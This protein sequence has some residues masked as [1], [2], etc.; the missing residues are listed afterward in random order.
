MYIEYDC[1]ISV[2]HSRL[3]DTL[4]NR[5]VPTAVIEEVDTLI[6]EFSL[7]DGSDDE[8]NDKVDIKFQS[9]S[10]RSCDKASDDETQEDCDDFY[11]KPSDDEKDEVRLND[12]GGSGDGYSD[13]NVEIKDDSS[14]ADSNSD[15]SDIDITDENESD[16]V[17]SADVA[18]ISNGKYKLLLNEKLIMYSTLYLNYTIMDATQALVCKTIGTTFQTVLNYQKPHLFLDIDREHL[19][20]LHNGNKHWILA[21]CSKN[22]VAV[23]DSLGNNL[24][25]TTREC[26]KSLF[27]FAI[28]PNGKLPVT[29]LNLPKQADGYNCGA[30]PIAYAAEIMAGTWPI[31]LVYDPNK[32][33]AHLV[34][35]LQ[36]E[37]LMPFPKL[38]RRK[39]MHDDGRI[40]EV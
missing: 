12:C 29:I 32:L 14:V 30:Y 9:A 10:I 35:C 11:D 22:I 38:E 24:S 17:S 27:L 40:V 16:E 7:V 8:S 1:D 26:R 3:Q 5:K 25:T 13:D 19:Q 2:L 21:F 34:Q 33:R 6:K 36:D 39:D 15:V 37:V 4:K 31:G 20:L 23:C 28:L 18:W